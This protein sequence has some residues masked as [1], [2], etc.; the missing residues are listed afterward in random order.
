[1]KEKY[2]KHIITKYTATGKP[3]YA[4]I[5]EDYIGFIYNQYRT[6]QITY[7]TYFNLKNNYYASN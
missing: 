1:M 6:G 3:Y 5:N 4:E 7:E 2:N